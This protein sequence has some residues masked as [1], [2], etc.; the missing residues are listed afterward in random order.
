MTI[1]SLARDAE[2]W[3]VICLVQDLFEE[4]GKKF[5]LI[6]TNEGEILEVEMLDESPI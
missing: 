5:R 6:V 2:N 3:V 1:F 4:E